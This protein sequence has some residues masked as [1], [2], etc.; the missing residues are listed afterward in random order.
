MHLDIIPDVH[1][2]GA[3][4]DAL[5]DA[6]G[7][8]HR[9]G[10]WQP[11]QAERGLVFLGD[12]IDRGPQQRAVLDRVRALEEDG[13]AQR[14][15]GN[16]EMNA[17]HWAMERD[18]APARRHSPGNQAHH[19]AFLD[20]YAGDAKGYAQALDWM[21]RAPFVLHH[22]PF[23]FVH[24]FWTPTV[25]AAAV[26]ALGPQ[27]QGTGFDGLANTPGFLD[28]AVP[29]GTAGSA[30]DLLTKGPETV[31]PDGFS[32]TTDHGIVRT[33]LRRA[34]WNQT[35]TTW[36]D[37]CAS[38]PDGSTLPPGTPPSLAHLGTAPPG[39]CVVFGHYWRRDWQTN[40]AIPVFNRQFACL[41]QSA[42][43]GA[44]EPL[45]ALTLDLT[46]GELPTTPAG[47]LDP[48]HLTVVR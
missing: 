42:G 18:G 27:V 15:M 23:V 40:G 47:F 20:A 8:Q 12:L 14:I 16:H 39:T 4:L 33:A 19:Q 3:K 43:A 2:Q 1:G 5:L 17:L 45:V 24:A 13:L 22:G 46:I 21:A 34:W 44:D 6:L 9:Q 30:L 10:R 35:P 31:L 37:G 26:T 36:V 41:D 28:A 29:Q 11:P 32:I 38:L 48:A 25:E 7:Y